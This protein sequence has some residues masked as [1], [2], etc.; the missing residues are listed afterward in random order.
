MSEP[1]LDRLFPR[2]DT[3]LHRHNGPRDA[4]LPA[5]LEACG[6][7][8]LDELMDRSLPAA[9]RWHGTLATPAAVGERQSLA[10][11]AEIAGRNKTW[12]SYLGMGYHGTITPPVIQRNILE[13]P[14]WYTQ[15]TPYQ[16]EISQGRLEAI[17]NY[18]TL[19]LDL[20]G[21]DCSNASLL[22][23]ATAAAEAMTM[24]KRVL[25]K[26]ADGKD[27]FL[28]SSD[29]H[30]QTIAVLRTRAEPLGIEVRVGDA[31]DF[32]FDE[33]V[34]GCLVQYPGTSGRIDPLA[35]VV[36]KAHAAGALV[37]VATDLLSLT[38]LEAPGKAGADAVV[39]TSQR[40][41]VP[42]GYGGPHA[43]F[44]AC[45]EDYKRMMP[46]RIIGVTRV[47]HGNRA[48]SMALQNSEQHI[49]RD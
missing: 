21:L 6:V 22:D 20:T 11:L 45:H 35:P 10:D 17:L 7:Q 9:I 47:V 34:F 3:F 37:G 16:A 19:V 44:L 12:R 30:P 28:V 1:A 15:Y 32:A 13:N 4:E 49:R 40:F 43:A 48:L 42:L 2:S 29:C 8:T 38:L 33:G 27:T 31:S 36:E 46:G 26:K 23:E 14:G 24:F 39:G 25:G 41:G 18:Q 5:M